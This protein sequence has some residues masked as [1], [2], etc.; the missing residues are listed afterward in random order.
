MGPENGETVLLLHGFPQTR[1]TWRNEVPALAEAGY[2]PVAFDQRGYSPGARPE[3]IDAYRMELLVSD[4]LGIADAIGADRFHIVGHDWGGQIAWLTTAFHPDR[5]QTLSVISRPHPQA[6]VRAMA[7]DPDQPKRSKHHRT[8]LD[9]DIADKMLANDAAHYRRGLPAVSRS[10]VDVY[11][12]TVGNRPA[13]DAALNWYRA[14]GK[15]DVT[16]QK[17]PAVTIP[18]LYVWGTIDGTVGRAAAEGTAAWVKAP[19]RFVELPGIGHFV[20]DQAPGA[21][22]P[23]LIEHIQSWSLVEQDK[24]NTAA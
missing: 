17:V 24:N 11:L 3:G 18:T 9:L 14:V 16:A 10:D 13:L 15:S 20:T 7:E 5:V 22:T 23:L 4:V 6:F 12:T 19:Y 1:Y 8:H 21:F 2:R